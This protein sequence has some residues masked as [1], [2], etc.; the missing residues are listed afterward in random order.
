MQVFGSRFGKPV[1]RGGHRVGDGLVFANLGPMFAAYFVCYEW[2]YAT[3][4]FGKND[5]GDRNEFLPSM[6]RRVKPERI[7]KSG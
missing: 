4:Q 6:L 2:C 7:Q 3:A 1:F 5:Q